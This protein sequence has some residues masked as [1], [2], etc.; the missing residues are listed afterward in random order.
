[1]FLFPFARNWNMQP[2]HLGAG[3]FC[4]LL[5]VFALI[6]PA[7]SS[8]TEDVVTVQGLSDLMYTTLRVTEN[9]GFCFRVANATHEIGCSG[10]TGRTGKPLVRAKALPEMSQLDDGF[11][12]VSSATE[13]LPLLQV[14]APCGHA[15]FTRALQI[16][17]AAPGCWY[18]V[19]VG[20]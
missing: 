17:A 9:T 7:G 16:I 19:S 2:Q 10:W 20:L 15:E 8:S 14:G 4:V 3:R 1:M 18:G 12:V 13:L 5:A 11:V 6:F